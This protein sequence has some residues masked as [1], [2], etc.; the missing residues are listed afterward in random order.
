MRARGDGRRA[1]ARKRN[2]IRHW[3]RRNENYKI[4]A[5]SEAVVMSSYRQRPTV[6]RQPFYSHILGTT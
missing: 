5:D 3:P 4:C 1:T 6:N 2:S